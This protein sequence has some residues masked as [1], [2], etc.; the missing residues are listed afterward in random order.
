MPIIVKNEDGSFSIDCRGMV[1]D[2]FTYESSKKLGGI[3]FQGAHSAPIKTHL[4]GK[5]DAFCINLLGLT[6]PANAIDQDIAG[7]IIHKLVSK[8]NAIPTPKNDIEV[9]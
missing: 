7:K 6:I 5:K 9:K 2:S 4:I 1:S 8:E 3:K